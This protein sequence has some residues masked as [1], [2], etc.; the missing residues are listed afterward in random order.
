MADHDRL[1]R[2]LKNPPKR[3][4]AEAVKRRKKRSSRH[5]PGNRKGELFKRQ[6]GRCAY[7]ARPMAWD[8]SAAG[9]TVDHVHPLSKGGK[10]HRD[11]IVLACRRCNS[12]KSDMT[13]A[14]FRVLL[15]SG[16]ELPRGDS[17]AAALKR[18]YR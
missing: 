6:K 10:N 12:A 13:A 16:S 18:G 9:V 7:C 15:A 11:N 3:I 5:Q 2:F 1:L 17:T 14:E 4:S 8:L